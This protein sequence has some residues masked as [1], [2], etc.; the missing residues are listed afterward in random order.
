MS[1][2]IFRFWGE[3]SCVLEVPLDAAFPRV[4]SV[5]SVVLN[6]LG[7][8]HDVPGDRGDCRTASGFEPTAKNP[9]SPARWEDSA[10]LPFTWSGPRGAPFS[11]HHSPAQ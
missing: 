2:R 1:E 4:T 11:P 9:G 10:P 6:L 7:F 8:C 3:H 5:A